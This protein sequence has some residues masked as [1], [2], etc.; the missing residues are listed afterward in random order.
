MTTNPGILSGNT[1]GSCRPVVLVNVSQQSSLRM[2]N[3]KEGK[4]RKYSIYNCGIL[5]FNYVY[6]KN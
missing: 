3:Q 5:N 1:D 4:R 6:N 2:K